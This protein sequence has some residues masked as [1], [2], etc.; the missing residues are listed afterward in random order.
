MSLRAMASPAIWPSYATS[1]IR[2]TR[3]T[4]AGPRRYPGDARAVCRAVLDACWDGTHVNASAGHFRQF[5]TRDLGFSAAALVRLGYRERVVSS[6]AW[7][8]DAWSVR[9]R[10]TT[11]IFPGRRPAD[12]YDMGVDSLPWLMAALRAAG[13]RT[14]PARSRQV[15]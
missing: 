12:V 4:W 11:T 10:I 1:F 13:S 3:R 5:W 6:L 7:A 8:L 2:S 14:M 9:G 15:R